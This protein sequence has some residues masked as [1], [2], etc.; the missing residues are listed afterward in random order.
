MRGYDNR[1]RSLSPQEIR[2]EIGKNS[3]F[4]L[5]FKLRSSPSHVD[6]LV[7]GRVEQNI[8]DVEGDFVI[9]KSDGFPTYHFANVVD[10]HLMRISHVLRGEEWLISTVKHLQLYRAFGWEPPKFGH[11]PLLL[12]PETGGK[13]SKRN[14]SVF[15]EQYQENGYF[16]RNL[17]ISRYSVTLPTSYRLKSVLAVLCNLTKGRTV[18]SFSARSI[19][20]MPFV[21]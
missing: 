9:L 13:L 12:D 15:V 19:P 11:L 20:E 2:N 21:T 5:R 4:V 6:D 16:C 7:F 1:C 10:D 14:R 8:A 18:L 3:P 17:I